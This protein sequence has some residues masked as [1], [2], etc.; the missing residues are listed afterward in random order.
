MQNGFHLDIEFDQSHYKKDIN[1]RE[2]K[3]FRFQIIIFLF[4]VIALFNYFTS[5]LSIDEKDIKFLL[6]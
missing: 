1:I 2:L 5:C 3:K 6:S 4:P